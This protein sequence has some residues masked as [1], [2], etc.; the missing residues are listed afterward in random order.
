MTKEQRII[1]EGLSIVE[2]IINKL[3]D[4]QKN[5][6]KEPECDETPTKCDGYDC[7]AEP[8]YEDDLQDYGCGQEECDCVYEDLT[9]IEALILKQITD[10]NNNGTFPS[11]AEAQAIA[12]LDEVNRKYNTEGE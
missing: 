1:L 3:E 10:H 11:L 8:E 4:I 6:A 7:R 12:I 2:D 5:D 9:A